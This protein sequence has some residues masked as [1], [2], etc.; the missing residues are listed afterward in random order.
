MHS[1]LQWIF[2]DLFESHA[3]DKLLDDKNVPC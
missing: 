1:E 3:F 2:K